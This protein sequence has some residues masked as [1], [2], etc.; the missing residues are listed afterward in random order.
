M[1]HSISSLLINRK[2]NLLSN[3]GVDVNPLIEQCHINRN[4][5]IAPYGRIPYNQSKKFIIETS[6]YNKYIYCKYSSIEGL[7]DLFPELFSLCLN[8]TSV[9]EAIKSFLNYRFIMGDSDY[10]TMIRQGNKLIIEYSNTDSAAP[11][12]SSIGHFY[13]INQ[14]LDK[15][16]DDFTC[17]FH[18]DNSIPLDRLLNNEVFS[19]KCLYAQEKNQMI[20]TSST[21]DKENKLF[22]KFLYNLQ[23][24]KL[25]S[26]R[27]ELYSVNKF[28]SRIK[29]IIENL[30][31]EKY[32]GNDLSL[33]DE[34]CGILGISRWTLNKKLNKEKTSFSELSRNIKIEKACSL[35]INTD[36]TINEI[37]ESCGFSSQSSFAKFM[38][39]NHNMSPI[40]YRKTF[41]QS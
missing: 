11:I 5:L 17:S 18:F 26:R 7:Y 3:I 40:K 32:L 23:K 16:L 2:I 36:R 35:L 9:I 24:I 31:K 38:N 25:E 15:Y 19:T 12:N 13:L 1:T 28:S 34:A 39:K 27:K 4:N 10:C 20:I 30:L 6:K 41:S 29:T 8:E 37:S 22:N 14:M 33:L 21:L